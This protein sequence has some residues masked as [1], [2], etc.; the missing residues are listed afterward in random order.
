VEDAG[1][2]TGAGHEVLL[3]DGRGVVLGPRGVIG[4]AEGAS[5]AESTVGGTV[6]EVKA[7]CDSRDVA[8]G[9]EGGGAGI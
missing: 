6:P 5:V 8:E 2:P 4:D 3:I 9:G 1:F 7:L